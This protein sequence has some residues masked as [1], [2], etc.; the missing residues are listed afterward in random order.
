MMPIGDPTTIYQR[1]VELLQNLIRFNTTNPPGNESECICYINRLLTVA[2]FETMLLARDPMRPNLIARLPGLGKA[3]PLLL[4]GHVDVVTTEN[5]RW[6][7]PPFEG[8]VVDGYVWGRG[9]FDDKG[10]VAMLLAA[11][12]RA[13]V[14]NLTPPGDVVLAIV[15]DEEH[16]GEYGA[17]YLVEN[18]PDL[19]KDIRYAIGESG[20]FTFYI[21]KQKFYPIMV[22][23]K[24][25]CV[26]KATVRGPSGHAFLPMR[27][28]ATAKLALLLERLDQ[29]RLPAHIAPV[30]RQMLMASSQATSFPTS[31]VL[32]LLLKPAL[33][34]KLLD[35]LGTKGKALDPLL[36][37]T[38]T[39]YTLHGGESGKYVI[40]GEIIIELTASILPGYTPQDVVAEL[41]GIVGE[42]VE[43]EV[44]GSANRPDPA[45]PDMGLFETLGGILR[46]ADP[47]GTPLPFLLPTP[48]DG[49]TFARLGIQTYG[50]LPMNLPAWFDIS[51]VS[52]A[53]DERIPAEALDFGA[54]AIYKA[55]QRFG[56]K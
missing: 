41:Q 25:A 5:Q 29:R 39:T 13:K 40:P 47:A 9:A 30:M 55:L 33:T 54:A 8:S 48:T 15:S 12:L 6:Q 44:I 37:N 3:Q 51:Q 17:M 28:T 26:I 1:P 42:E 56:G 14:E 20:G 31:L 53:A 23:E 46:E 45:E 36:H 52:H 19:F 43:F 27:G 50:F 10:G 38:V 4:Y 7:H 22:A 16:G 24:Q 11:F 32:S 2:G 34:D 18:H 49:R 35:A 21:G